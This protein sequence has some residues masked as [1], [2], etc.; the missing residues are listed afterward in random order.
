MNFITL[1]IV[2]FYLSLW[3][4]SNRRINSALNWLRLAQE[5]YEPN[6]FSE[7]YSEVHILLPALEEQA[8]VNSTLSFFDKELKELEP[9][10]IKIWIITSNFESVRQSSLNVEKHDLTKTLV[11]RWIIKNASQ[12]FHLL[13]D[14]DFAGSKATKVQFSIDKILSKHEQVEH[15]NILFGIY[16]F[17][18]RPSLADTIKEIAM[19]KNGGCDCEVYQQ[20]PHSIGFGINKYPKFSISKLF[21]I[22]H[23]ERTFSLEIDYSRNYKRHSFFSSPRGCMGAGL[24]L[25]GSIF[26]KI[27][28]IP[29]HSDDIALGYRLD[30]LSIDRKILHSPTLV[31]PTNSIYQ[32]AKQYQRIFKGVFSL[33]SEINRLENSLSTKQKL[34]FRLRALN[35]FFRDTSFSF[36]AIIILIAI[37]LYY[38]SFSFVWASLLVTMMLALQFA[39]FRKLV[40]C[41][42]TVF[43][44]SKTPNK[45]L[46]LSFF[47]WVIGPFVFGLVYFLLL[48]LYVFTTDKPLL[49]AENGMGKTDKRPE[50]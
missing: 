44:F 43:L 10:N 26:Q 42:N 32:L 33:K 27:G 30:L 37:P 23:L 3:V 9:V 2:F 25:K 16:D 31:Q 6:N 19:H 48:F 12:H 50:E 1:S 4:A 49:N 38:M 20:V 21:S 41:A 18:S 45:R 17:D 7:F 8:L 5:K 34:S 14:P 13:H 28:P 46:Q 29:K 47:D 36:K 11:E 22:G 35:T 24:F 39:T 40:V 15:K